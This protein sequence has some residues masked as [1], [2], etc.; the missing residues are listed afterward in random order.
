M[1][2][3][4][5]SLSGGAVILVIALLRALL[6]Y[7]LPK[8]FFAA[9]WALPMARLL[10]PF[11]IPA[12][13]SVY[14]LIHRQTAP[15]PAASPVPAPIQGPAVLPRGA[16]S[17][18][19]NSGPAVEPLALLWLTGALVCAG[20]YAVT[21]AR[22]RLRFRESL[23]VE[24]E[25]VAAWLKVH[26]LRRRGSVRQS[27]RVAAPLTYGVL[28]PVILL[29][30][31]TDYADQA[32]LSAVLAHELA[33][34]RRFD[35]LGKLGFVL[36][37]CVHWFNPLVW[38]M[39][40][41]ANRDMEL[42]CDQAVLREGQAP[43]GYARALLRMEERKSGHL[44][45]QVLGSHFSK[46]SIE[47][48]IRAIMTIKKNSVAL[49]L[50]ALVVTGGAAAVFA[51]SAKAEETRNAPGSYYT[52]EMQEDSLII[53]NG[54]TGETL[55]STDGGETWTTLNQEEWEA[56]ADMPNVEWW[57][58]EEYA[59]WLENEKK[60]LESIVGSQGWTPST[61]WFTWTPEMVAETIAEYE[62]TLAMI[63]EGYLV[64][65][66]VDGDEDTLL[67][68]NPMDRILS[69]EDENTEVWEDDLIAENAY[70]DA[71][72]REY[73]SFGLDYEYDAKIQTGGLKMA[74]DGQPVRSLFDPERQWRSCANRSS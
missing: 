47:E 59:D 61:G 74:W 6:L 3:L 12:A 13:F 50:A 60:N 36:A 30:K 4:Q 49:L 15:V 51:T 31:T 58:A 1:S 71:L 16:V 70:Y 38:L 22:C 29:P 28:R 53:S 24:N 42:A 25:A 26:P 68:M 10:V 18:A 57:T 66:F 44:E 48:R 23:P 21:Y 37:L 8:R 19:E 9:L 20:F 54:A 11:S 67:I 32:T 69:T 45:Q 52:G 64:S 17:V 43:A 34:I 65:K 46:N 14:T 35:A 56:L 2:L 63:R 39:C 40:I 7:R 72:F 5:M 33:H 73:E 62:E 41:L 55:Y 27:D